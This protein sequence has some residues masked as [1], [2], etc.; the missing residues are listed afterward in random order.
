MNMKKVSEALGLLE[1][2]GKLAAGFSGMDMEHVAKLMGAHARKMSP[3]EYRILW[4]N[5][6]YLLTDNGGEINVSKIEPTEG[7]SVPFVESGGKVKPEE[8]A[9][10]LSGYLLHFG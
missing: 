4:K 5:K 10:R 9:E 7:S 1:S 6:V 8:L 3:N 2:V